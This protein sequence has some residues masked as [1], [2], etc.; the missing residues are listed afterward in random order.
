MDTTVYVGSDNT[1]TGIKVDLA[2]L[3][4]MLAAFLTDG[5]RRIDNSEKNT[6]KL[7]GDLPG[8]GQSQAA[9]PGAA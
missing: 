7:R 3:E 2:R 9:T 8:A 5:V 1:I 6:E 4:G